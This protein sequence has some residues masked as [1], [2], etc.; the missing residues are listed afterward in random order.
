MGSRTWYARAM[1]ATVLLVMV[2]AVA[3]MSV[4]CG[5]SA[6]AATSTLK[7]GQTDDGKT[8]SVKVG[9]TIQVVIPGNPTT[10]YE[11][12]AALSDKDAAL[13]QQV[14]EPQ[15][16]ANNTDENRVGSGGVFTLTFKATAKGQ[17]VLKLAYARS[18]ESVQPIQ[19]FTA[20]LNIE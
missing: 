8:F 17:A 9:D 16:A 5:S 3:M 14:G 6:G 1:V 11:W 4:G 10:G 2:V 18:F 15:Y 12:T 19:T 20:T 13:L 7:L